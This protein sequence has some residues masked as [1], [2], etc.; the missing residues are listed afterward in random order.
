M[1]AGC[2]GERSAPSAGTEAFPVA[3]PRPLCTSVLAFGF[4][5]SW[6]DNRCH[7]T[8]RRSKVQEGGAPAHAPVPG[9]SVPSRVARPPL[10][11]VPVIGASALRI[12]V[13]GGVRSV[14]PAAQRARLSWDSAASEESRA[15]SEL[16]QRESNGRRDRRGGARCCPRTEGSG[17]A[18]SRSPFLVSS[19]RSVPSAPLWL[20]HSSPSLP[21][22]LLFL[23]T[24]VPRHLSPKG[25]SPPLPSPHPLPS[26]TELI[27]VPLF[28][29][30]LQRCL[31]RSQVGL[32]HF[33]V[34]GLRERPE[35]RRRGSGSIWH[36]GGGS[37]MHAEPAFSPGP[38]RLLVPFLCLF[39]FCLPG[40]RNPSSLSCSSLFEQRR[41]TRRRGAPVSLRTCFLFTAARLL[42]VASPGATR[43]SGRSGAVG[44]PRRV[45]EDGGHGQPGWLVG[46]VAEASG[47]QGC[48]P[49]C[50]DVGI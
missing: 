20:S 37:W 4:V 17:G 48:L 31:G 40:P 39:C 44:S 2:S 26:A 30:V 19:P 25:G 34:L 6:R 16:G 41:A 47:Q 49:G 43:A 9:G 24:Q 28:T 42:A 29:V 10:P 38:S 14:T 32:V 50:L 46:P 35:G 15:K 27:Y 3:R 21:G 18:R 36:G 13:G 45:A 11:G 1:A 33:C 7:G 5:S 12:L 23:W 22:R 8:S